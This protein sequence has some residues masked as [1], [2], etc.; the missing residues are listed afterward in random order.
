[1]GLLHDA[2]VAC[3]HFPTVGGCCAD[4]VPVLG[5]WD[6]LVLELPDVAREGCLVGLVPVF[7]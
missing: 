5:E 4:D 7:E 2:E 6:V 1:M 3:S